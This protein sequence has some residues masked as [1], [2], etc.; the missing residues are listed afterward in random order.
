MKHR[1]DAAPDSPM[2]VYRLRD[3]ACYEADLLRDG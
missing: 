1:N 2:R 3:G